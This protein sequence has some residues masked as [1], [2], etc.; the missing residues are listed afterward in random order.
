MRLRSP[1][2]LVEV[3]GIFEMLPVNKNLSGYVTVEALLL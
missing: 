2:T 3:G 1:A